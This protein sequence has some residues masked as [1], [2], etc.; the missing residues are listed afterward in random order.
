V[1]TVTSSNEE[2]F[3]TSEPALPK[4]ILFTDK[5]KTTPLYQSLSAQLQKKAILGEVKKDSKLQAKYNVNKYP[6]LFVV[7]A[8]EVEPKQYEGE[9][10][11]DGIRAFI[12]THVPSFDEPSNEPEEPASKGKDKKK[13]KSKESYKNY[14]VQLTAANF[15]S[16]VMNSDS[17]WIVEFFAPW[18]GHC[19]ALAPEWQ[20]AADSLKG[21][22][23][24]G[25][26]D[27]TVEQQLAAR[28]G[29]KGYPTI[30][31]FPATKEAKVRRVS[32][33][34]EARTAQALSTFAVGQLPNL[35]ATISPEEIASW[36]QNSLD[37]PKFL[38]VTD[39][40]SVPPLFK[41]IAL[42]FNSKAKF[43]AILK[44]SKALLDQI[45]G[46]SSALNVPAL[47]AIVGKEQPQIQAYSGILG[48]DPISQFVRHL[49]GE[50]EPASS[51]AGASSS[52]SF[53][54]DEGIIVVRSQKEF[55]QAC[56]SRLGLCVVAFPTILD[57][58]WE[59]KNAYAEF[60]AVKQKLK[61][62]PFHFIWLDVVKQ[63]A[64]ANELRIPE[65]GSVGLA[66][67]HPGKKRYAV[68]VG[69]FDQEGVSEFLDNLTRGKIFTSTY[70]TL[71]AI[72]DEEQASKK[73][74]DS[75]SSDTSEE[76]GQC[77]MPPKDEL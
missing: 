27:A 31:V 13:E 11:P 25:A 30:K 8:N 10:T 47:L 53:E 54:K 57:G 1:Q 39:K 71:P 24:F 16:L 72:I 19:K 33:Y 35:V 14:N 26:V 38:L 75:C 46:G 52:S 55:E 32:D 51:E 34:N 4:F 3:L 17:V 45:T 68:F 28:Y 56:T 58:E 37:F 6:S 41:S 49:I 40:A 70:E 50:A 66:A 36:Y 61:S 42:E 43:G 69:V 15:D 73:D 60:E 74:A 29:I 63:R 44:G 23:K 2:K 22:V 5:P 65:D 18:C 48:L 21:I 7:P 20:K 12:K 76:S 62:K 64:L 77:S 67:I 9:I 59:N